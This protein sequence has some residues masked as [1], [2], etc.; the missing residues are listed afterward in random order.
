MP[1]LQDG[2]TGLGPHG[3]VCTMREQRS[4]TSVV[5]RLWR[6]RPP[7][8]G[9]SDVS[10]PT[11]ASALRREAKSV[12][13]SLETGIRARSGSELLVNYE[14]GKLSSP[15]YRQANR[16]FQGHWAWWVTRPTRGKS[17]EDLIRATVAWGHPWAPHA[18]GRAGGR[19]RHQW[20]PSSPNNLAGH[21][22]PNPPTEF[23]GSKPD[24]LSTFFPNTPFLPLPESQCLWVV[25]WASLRGLGGGSL[26]PPRSGSQTSLPTPATVLAC[27]AATFSRETTNNLAV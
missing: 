22:G 11:H 25:S 8:R 24:D 27:S 16:G 20:E 7:P 19:H 21:V 5:K 4:P 1:S 13:L 6:M 14:R 26:L 17:Q 23:S 10:G 3:A 15:L 9:P 12:F 2:K 18:S